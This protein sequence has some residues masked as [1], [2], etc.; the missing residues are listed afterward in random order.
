[1]GLWFDCVDASAFGGISFWVRG[2]T[3]PGTFSLSASFRQ[4]SASDARAGGSCTGGAEQ[5]KDPG[6]DPIPLTLD[7]TR[8]DLPWSAFTQGLS[9]GAP[10]VPNG[11]ELTGLT[12][13]LPILWA[14]DPSFV[15]NPNDMT[16][17]PTFLPMT[18]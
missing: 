6:V 16:D 1:M 13:G 15:D 11:D 4:T 18:R 10:F 2:T 9:N 7:W 5:C 8:I 14:A 17:M 3:A 12:F